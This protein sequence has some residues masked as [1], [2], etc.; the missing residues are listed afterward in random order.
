MFVDQIQKLQQQ[1]TD[2]YVVVDAT[3]PEL[4][5]FAGFVGFVKTVNMSGRALVEFQEY[6]ANIGWFDIELDF[7]KIVPKPEARAA[8]KAEKPAAKKAAAPAAKAPGDTAKA[9]APA[10]KKP[11]AIE[12]ARMGGAAKRESGSE[13]AKAKPAAPE[14]TPA[15]KPAGGKLSTADI[16]AAARAKQAGEATPA[17]DT[18]ATSEPTATIVAESAVG[19]ASRRK[20]RWQRAPVASTAT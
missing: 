5:R 3:R 2:Q 16:L 15:A 7:L 4:A 10:G 14:K 12:L 9:A 1:Y 20:G 17:A 19:Y 18:A 13:P 8:T 6:Y 11:S